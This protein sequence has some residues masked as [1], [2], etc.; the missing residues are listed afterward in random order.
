MIIYSVYS[1]DAI[2]KDKNVSFIVPMA[3]ILLV[4]IA[5]MYILADNLQ[6]LDCAFGCDTFALNQTRNEI[7]C[8][9]VGNSALRFAF[10]IIT[11]IIVLTLSIIF[12]CFRKRTADPDPNKNNPV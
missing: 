12:F 5:P 4:I 8:N 2:K 1:F 11:F 7:G 10:T 6:P 9:R 3:C